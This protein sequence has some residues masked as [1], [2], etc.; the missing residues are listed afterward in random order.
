[1][2]TRRLQAGKDRQASLAKR[3]SQW[4][5]V[6]DAASLAKIRPT[7]EDLFATPAPPAPPSAPPVVIPTTGG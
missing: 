5:Y 4:Y 2:Y 3:F 6:V 7:K 1:G